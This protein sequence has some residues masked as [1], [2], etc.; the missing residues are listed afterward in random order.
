[1]AAPLPQRRRWP[2]VA[3][4]LACL[5]LLALAGGAS[6]QCSAGYFRLDLVRSSSLTDALGRCLTSFQ[7]N[8]HSNCKV[9]LTPLNVAG[10]YV[11]AIWTGNPAKTYA[12]YVE[13]PLVEGVKVT[14]ATS[15]AANIRAALVKAFEG[16]VYGFTAGG[17]ARAPLTLSALAFA[18]GS[19]MLT[20]AAPASTALEYAVTEVALPLPS[21]V[22]ASLAVVSACS[23]LPSPAS[24]CLDGSVLGGV[25]NLC[26]AG[27]YGIQM[28][29]DLKVCALCPAGSYSDTGYGCTS[30]D[31]GTV[32]DLGAASC[33]TNCGPGKFATGGSSTCLPCPPSTFSDGPANGLCSTWEHGWVGLFQLPCLL[34]RLQ[35]LRT[36]A[37][38]LHGSHIVMVGRMQSC[39][40]SGAFE[41]KAWAKCAS[42]AQAS[43]AIRV[44]FAMEV[45]GDCSIDIK[46]ITDP[47]CSDPASSDPASSAG[48]PYSSIRLR[49]Y[50][51]DATTI[52][53]LLPSDAAGGPMLSIEPAAGASS[54]SWTFWAASGDASDCNA[55][56]ITGGTTCTTLAP[57]VVGGQLVSKPSAPISRCPARS[58]YV[59]DAYCYA[60]PPGSYRP[61]G[62][63][64]N[65][66][67]KA[68]CATNTYNPY[69]GGTPCITCPV[70]V[71]SYP[72]ATQCDIPAIDKDC[73]LANYDGAGMQYDPVSQ[74]CLPCPAGTAH[75]DALKTC[76]DC[77]AGTYSAAGA[78]VCTACPA[79][80][81]SPT[82]G[83]PN[84]EALTGM[85]GRHCML[86]PRGSMA[87]SGNQTAATVAAWQ[88]TTGATF[89]DA[90]PPGSIQ[91]SADPLRPC[92]AC[93]DSNPLIGPYTYRTGDATP[94]N[95][96]CKQVP[97]GYRLK[98]AATGVD[99]NTVIDLCQPG[100]VSF[101]SADGLTRTPA[102]QSACIGCADLIPQ[103]DYVHTCAPHAG[104]VA[105]V[106][107][108]AGTVPLTAGI[109]GASSTSSCAPCPDGIYRDAYTKSATCL[110]CGEGKE[111]GPSGNRDCTLCRPGMYM[112]T[113]M[114]AANQQFC[115]PCP[116]NS[117]KQ[118]Y[119]ATSCDACGRGYS[120]QDTGNT[121]CT[122][123][124]I[125]FYSWEEATAGQRL[126][127]RS[128][129][130]P[131]PSSTWPALRAHG[132]MR[133]AAT[134]ATSAPPAGTPSPLAPPS[135]RS[136]VVCTRGPRL[137]KTLGRLTRRAGV[138]TGH[139]AHRCLHTS[140][141]CPRPAAITACPPPSGADVRPQHLFWS[142][143]HGVLL[144]PRRLLRARR[145]RPL[146]PLQ[147]W[148][149]LGEPQVC[150]L[151]AVP[152]GLP[153][154]DRRD[155][156]AGSLPKGHVQQQG[157]RQ[158]MCTLVGAAAITCCK[159]GHGAQ[160]VHWRLRVWVGFLSNMAGASGVWP[161]T[162][163]TQLASC[164][165]FPA[166]PAQVG[167][168]RP[169]TT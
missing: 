114:A 119:G 142:T 101:W 127:A 106:P 40:L 51:T 144:V 9:S 81:Y 107:C 84:Q 169:H 79:G 103:V 105:C 131:L 47:A 89:C 115:S 36:V 67:P 122:P 128:S 76:V 123:C 50:Y 155:G 161:A 100:T 162:Q 98:D 96:E 163:G 159:A 121:E 32:S 136:E 43:P 78:A 125:G 95:N 2:A 87:L 33:T 85:A 108:P 34:R 65:T 73:F 23:Q 26:P 10:N 102:S 80:Q 7:V 29:D 139:P 111:A 149:L 39:G 150:H 8:L 25:A 21:Q 166:T 77:P 158:G 97:S 118:S 92:V 110:K 117:Y 147:A 135:A 38:L 13:C 74:S 66:G 58:Y 11:P 12:K 60:C 3:L 145:Q 62:S 160:G 5:C 140:S 112:S 90:C 31:A 6:A 61:G 86:Y 72:G 133:R 57:A 37:A 35:C 20:R 1:M 4:L 71:T 129:T 82:A 156:Q 113:A 22:D 46:P 137:L 151:Q 132:M 83:M 143:G 141:L 164:H 64:T 27:R 15:S 55:T 94:E 48:Y 109:P 126:L 167:L 69:L 41:V 16:H 24:T 134:A 148:V 130:P 19:V 49:A 93:A 30:C 99:P 168:P 59:P 157:R 116:K 120:T 54:L 63:G 18:N 165:F 42:W 52:R 124:P 17:A 152:Q 56:Q 146:H 14:P 45:A 70:G 53:S 75:D 91:D 28:S 138:P 104:M 68:A 88:I 153:V 154:P 44:Q